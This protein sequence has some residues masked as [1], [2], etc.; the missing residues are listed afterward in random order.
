MRSRG[1]HTDAV[2]LEDRVFKCVR[3]LMV[4][5]SF[6]LFLDGQLSVGIFMLLSR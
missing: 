3:W 4:D 2:I 6:A 5:S 1:R